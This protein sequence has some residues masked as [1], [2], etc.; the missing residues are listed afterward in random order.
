MHEVFVNYV[1]YD[2][3]LI[4]ENYFMQGNKKVTENRTKSSPPH[5]H[6]TRRRLS[7]V[8]SYYQHHKTDHKI[9]AG[10]IY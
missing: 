8:V 10:D 1:S 6:T 7:S 9:H 4:I 2:D 5:I 3:Y